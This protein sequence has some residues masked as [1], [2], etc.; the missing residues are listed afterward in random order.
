MSAWKGSK[1]DGKQGHHPLP[2]HEQKKALGQ[3]YDDTTV[4]VS[5]KDHQKI[6]RDE[7]EAGPIV[8]IARQDMRTALRHSRKNRPV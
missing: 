3:V 5:P 6:H 4:R 7:R 1:A 2:K 8:S